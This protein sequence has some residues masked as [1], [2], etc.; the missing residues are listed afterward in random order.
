MI[1]LSYAAAQQIGLVEPGSGE[2]ELTIVKVGKGDR[3]PPV[4]YSVAAAEPPPL[5]AA[6][7]PVP[8]AVVQ[9]APPPP[10][11]VTVENVQVVE[12]HAG[13]E[14]RRQVSASGTSIETVPV[15]PAEPPAVT[16]APKPAPAPVTPQPKPPQRVV[17]TSGGKFFVQA[18]AFSIE[19]NAKALQKQLE[20]IGEQSTIEHTTLFR[21]RIGPFATRDEALRERAH[22]ESAGM[23]A[24]IVTD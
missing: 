6:P 24:I 21:V 15:K 20:K 17:P 16:P 13:V 22:L 9:S 8:A 10:V 3:E 2:V 23:S 19:A 1:D 7:A 18:G 14:T 4:P 12:E 5:S 11:P